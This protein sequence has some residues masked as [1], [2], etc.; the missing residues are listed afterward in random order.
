M[1]SQGQFGSMMEFL[2]NVNKDQVVITCATL[3]VGFIE[4][5]ATSCE[6]KDLTFFDMPLTGGSIG[7]QT[8]GLTLLVGGNEKELEK[9]KNYIRLYCTGS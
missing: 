2:D 9:D 4:E 6:K 1:N 7:A 3:S 5:L 8:G